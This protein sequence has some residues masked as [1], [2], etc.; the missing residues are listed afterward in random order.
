M[1]LGYAEIASKVSMNVLGVIFDSKPNWSEKV[2]SAVMKANRSL[3]AL[4]LKRKYFSDLNCYNYSLF[5]II[6]SCY[7]NMLQVIHIHTINEH[8]HIYH[9]NI[10]VRTTDLNIAYPQE[11]LM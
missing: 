10:D 3:N 2:S 8:Y 6:G 11:M 5:F 7:L 1:R 9:S 4:K